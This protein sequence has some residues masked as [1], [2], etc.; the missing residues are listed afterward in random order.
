ME[1]NDSWDKAHYQALCFQLAK[2]TK[3]GL[4]LLM[5]TS[6]EDNVID[7]AKSCMISLEKGFPS[8]GEERN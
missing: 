8:E 3:L 5:T 1:Q 4:K 7:W 6:T 2:L